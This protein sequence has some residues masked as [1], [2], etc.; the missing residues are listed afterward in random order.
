M[1]SQTQLKGRPCLLRHWEGVEERLGG[2]HLL[3]A[4]LEI[5]GIIIHLPCRV[6]VRTEMNM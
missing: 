1:A 2:T 4:S 6:A 3:Q 5:L